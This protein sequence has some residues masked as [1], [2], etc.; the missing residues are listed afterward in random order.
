MS[1]FQLDFIYME[2]F[3]GTKFQS[4]AL[5]T[6]QIKKS[7]FSTSIFFLLCINSRSCPCLGL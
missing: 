6:I 1:T 7:I 3:S 5:F 4:L 2:T